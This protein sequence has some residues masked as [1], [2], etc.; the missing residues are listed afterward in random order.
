MGDIKLYLGKF[1]FFNIS[2]NMDP[3]I[4]VTVFLCC[5][6]YCAQLVVAETNVSDFPKDLERARKCKPSKTCTRKGG[7]AMASLISLQ[8]V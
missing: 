8:M 4:H 3:F 1:I 2:T 6:A 5:V 7:V